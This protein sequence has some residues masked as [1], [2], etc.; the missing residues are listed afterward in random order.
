M[1]RRLLL[2][3]LLLP[4]VACVGAAPG[5]TVILLHGLGRTSWSLWRLEQALQADGYQVINITYPSRENS[6]EDLT[7][8]YL[9][10]L[11]ARQRAAPRL[12]FVTHSMGG[13][14]LR[15]Y[16]RDHAVP[17]LGRVVM[18][19][20]PNAGSELAD[21][22]KTTWLYRTVDGPAGQQLGTTGLP[23][24]LGPWPAGAGELGIIAGNVSLNPVFSA[25]L[26][27]PNDGKVTVASTRLA[28]MQDFLIVPYSHTWLAWRSAVID[29]I[30]AF[31][32]SG[33]FHPPAPAAPGPGP[34]P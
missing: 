10:P 27:G 33:R 2:F 30:R 7:R 8:D 21:R 26:P 11:I 23:S 9:G 1:S 24:A 4:A 18:L 6:I 32:Q 12:H 16:L 20:P 15:C 25:L 19:A 14:L 5:E 17:N 13:I 28:G 29:P 31:L 34:R 3:L 22:L